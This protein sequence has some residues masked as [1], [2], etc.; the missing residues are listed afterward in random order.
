M[1]SSFATERD[2]SSRGKV[3]LDL[4]IFRLWP[5]TSCKRRRAKKAARIEVQSGIGKGHLIVIT[6]TTSSGKR[7][8]T[9]WRP[10]VR[11]SVLS[12]THG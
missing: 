2:T 4:D 1:G 10:S 12:V 7:N 5:C 9:V 3:V 11:L 6:L 8:V